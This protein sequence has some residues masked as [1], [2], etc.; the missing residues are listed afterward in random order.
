MEMIHMT[1]CVKTAAAVLLSASFATLGVGAAGAQTADAAM[2]A[3]LESF[4]DYCADY[5]DKATSAGVVLST[6]RPGVGYAA[7]PATQS[8]AMQQQGSPQA[9]KN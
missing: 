6:Y 8:V 2:T 1:F 9:K 7:A 5:T 4:C 3:S